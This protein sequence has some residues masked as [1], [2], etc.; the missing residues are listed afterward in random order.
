MV[1]STLV[2]MAVW[3]ESFE[4]ERVFVGKTGALSIIGLQSGE[5]G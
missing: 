1:V 3:G 4:G 2:D 5:L